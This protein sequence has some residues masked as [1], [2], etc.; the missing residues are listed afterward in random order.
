[1][2]FI[3][4]ILSFIIV[5]Q[6]ILFSFVLVFLYI[7][8]KNKPF[9]ILSIFMLLSAVYFGFSL[10]Y[11]YSTY[12]ILAYTYYLSL[13]VALLFFPLFYI[14]IKSVTKRN[15]SLSS[16]DLIHFIPAVLVLIINSPYFFLTYEQK[17]WFV[18]GGYR[19][20]TDN[21]LIIYLRNINKIGVFGIINIQLLVYVVL[22][23][24]YYKNYKKEIENI[25]SY[26]ENIDLAWIRVLITF[27]LILFLVID[28][29]H[30]FNIKTNLPHRIIFNCIMLIFNVIIFTYGLNQRNIYV[31]QYD[32]ETRLLPDIIDD[33]N[34]MTFSENKEDDS[35]K[36]EEKNNASKY[37]NSSLTEVQKDKIIR[38][39]EKY[40]ETKPYYYSRLTIDDVAL[41]L[42]INSKY[43]SQ[44]INEIYKRNFYSYINNYRINDS[45]Q[46]LVSGEFGNYSMEGIAKTVGFN[47]KSSFYTAFKNN[48]GMTPLEFKMNNNSEN[49]KM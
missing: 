25:F 35:K 41:A 17:Q 11:Y 37:K 5:Y 14:Y 23:F 28:T 2:K 22:S 32:S 34:E 49:A 20:I 39:L 19:Q 24:Y 3:D 13:P 44:V 7:K 45:K 38:D 29:V 6:S 18:S 9:K 30:F 16:R 47:S 31:K 27:F 33:K 8:T 12:K 4:E 26:K 36:T 40:M 46:M 42:N 10:S 15:F 48:T 1:M 43:L 21:E